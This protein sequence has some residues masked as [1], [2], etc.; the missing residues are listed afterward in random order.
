MIR[1]VL[2]GL[3]VALGAAVVA[4]AGAG[5]AEAGQRSPRVAVAGFQNLRPGTDTDYIGAGAAETLTTKLTGVPGLVAVERAQVRKVMEEQRFQQSD[6]VDPARAVQAG[7]LFGADRIVVG[8]FL[9]EG[10]TV[11]FNVRVLDVETATVLNA[12]S[13][14]GARGEALFDLFYKVAEAVIE[15][16]DKKVVIVDARPVVKDAPPAERIVLTEDEKRLLRKR[17]TTNP[18]AWEAFARGDAAKDL[19]EEIAWFSKA[20]ALDPQ[21][22]WA[23]NDR[24]VAYAKKG[25]QD[26]AIA[27]CDK[28][29]GLDPKYATAYY[30][31][32]AAY[33][34][35]GDQDRAI[36]DYDRVVE[37]DPKLAEA[38]YNRG[39]AYGMKGDYDREIADYD[40][41]IEL[42]PKGVKFYDR[43]GIAYGKKRDYDRAIAN[44]DR[45][46]EL[47]PKSAKAH[48]DRAVAWYS[49]KD[50]LKAWADVKR[51]QALGGSPTPAFLEALR[52]ASGRQE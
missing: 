20:I 42:D 9:V 15:S 18:Q 51:C 14:S 21:Y 5:A 10:N 52:K 28:A 34:K 2:P 3:T 30:N 47:D 11:L 31:R 35:K 44:F 43:R 46:I 13:V 4:L 12:A 17:G 25:D 48:Q 1:R 36:A 23:Y 19:D 37:L 32:G 38:Y 50:Y 27:D 24:G 29:I 16:F 45:A 40:K 8:T 7:R 33:A 41:A 26:R 22:V 49:K 39:L 6:L